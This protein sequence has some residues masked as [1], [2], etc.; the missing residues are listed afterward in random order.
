VRDRTGA[1]AR[2]GQME[3]REVEVEK[4]KRSYV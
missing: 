3:I 4:D 1:G 2:W